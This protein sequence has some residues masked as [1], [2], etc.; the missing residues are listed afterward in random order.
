[1]LFNFRN[2]K[3]QW[4][5]L[6][7]KQQKVFQQVDDDKATKIVGKVILED[8]KQLPDHEKERWSKTAHLKRGLGK[9]KTLKA[10][11]QLI[12]KMVELGKNSLVVR[13]TI[14]AI[15]QFYTNEIG[16]SSRND[17]WVFA[18]VQDWMLK[19]M[20]Y[21]KDGGKQK[22]VFITPQR[23]LIDWARGTGGADCD[24]LA[25]LFSALLKTIG[26]EGAVVILDAHKSGQFN[27]AMGACKPKYEPVFQ[28]KWVP[29]E[30]T[31]KEPFGWS[32]QHG[33][34]YFLTSSSA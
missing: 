32:I 22:E 19:N 12:S 6:I 30:L 24:D 2:N 1:M 14:K 5:E 7:N 20:N 25:I 23:Q 11:D 21:I 29:V 26:K 33:K 3:E 17:V 18:S 27:H 34:T 9:N 8:E 4:K 16:F 28:G 31:R 13:D 10:Y 15:T